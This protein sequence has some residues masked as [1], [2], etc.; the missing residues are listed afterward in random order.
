[1]NSLKGEVQAR[2]SDRIFGVWN[3]EITS[4]SVVFCRSPKYPVTLFGKFRE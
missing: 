1:M 2:G 3:T 4:V